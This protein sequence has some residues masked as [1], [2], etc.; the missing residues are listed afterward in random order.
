MAASNATHASRMSVQ[1]AGLMWKSASTKTHGLCLETSMKRRVTYAQ[2]SRTWE[3]GGRGE[4][5]A[6]KKT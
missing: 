1:S 5:R 6:E 3:D 4:E 2:V